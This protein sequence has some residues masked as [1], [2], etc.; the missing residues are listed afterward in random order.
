MPPNGQQRHQNSFLQIVPMNMHSG[1]CQQ[2]D[3]IQS[4]PNHLSTQVIQQKQIHF[5]RELLT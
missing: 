3:K 1:D 2:S 5:E 4:S